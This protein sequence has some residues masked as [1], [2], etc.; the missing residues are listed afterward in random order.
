M[1]TQ[2]FINLKE[3]KKQAILEAAVHEFSRVPYSAASINQIIKEADISRGSF[4]TYFEDKDDLMRYILSG[5]RERCL[6]EIL[7]LMDEEGGH[8]FRIPLRM[9]EGVMEEGIQGRNYQLFRNMLSDLSAVDQNQLFG[10]KG[11]LFQD[12]TFRNFVRLL[13]DHLDQ[14]HCQITME[15]LAYGAEMAMMIVIKALTLFYKNVI[16]KDKILTVA[17]NELLILER[18]VCG[19]QNLEEIR[20]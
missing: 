2:R 14:D 6:E 11:F 3:E 17:R 20:A 4:Y 7:R 12:E 1:P 16:E 10:I 18:G 8:F 13:H 5:A 19:L 15:A 9:L